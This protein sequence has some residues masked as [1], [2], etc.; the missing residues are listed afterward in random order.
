MCRNCIFS[1]APPITASSDA[2]ETNF[3][4]SLKKGSTLSCQL[5]ASPWADHRQQK[6]SAQTPGFP[7]HWAQAQNPTQES[8]QLAASRMEALPFRSKI[9]HQQVPNSQRCRA[10]SSCGRLWSSSLACEVDDTTETWSCLLYVEWYSCETKLA[11]YKRYKKPL[12]HATSHAP[13]H[14]TAPAPSKLPELWA[15][16]LCP[17]PHKSLQAGCRPFGQAHGSVAIPLQ[18]QEN[19]VANAQCLRPW[20]WSSRCPQGLP[21][22]LHHGWPADMAPN[23]R[24]SNRPTFFPQWYK[25]RRAKRPVIQ[26]QTHGPR[27]KTVLTMKLISIQLSVRSII[28]IQLRTKLPEMG[29]H[30]MH[31]HMIATWPV[32]LAGTGQMQPASIP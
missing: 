7:H 1:T 28:Q 8:S 30:P 27:L 14:C 22:S 23:A 21:C 29:R 3:L 10:L 25:V 24:I 11:T 12:S 17:P 26:C 20:K 15:A 4:S 31:P 16:D 19:P 9:F 18:W 32:A 6:G 13:H 5:R 2:C